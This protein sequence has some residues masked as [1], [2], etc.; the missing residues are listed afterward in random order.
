MSS[1]GIDGDALVT[2][3]IGVVG[4]LLTF[5]GVRVTA[6][7][8]EKASEPA[9]WQSLTVEMKKFFQEQLAERDKRIDALEQREASRDAYDRWLA[10]LSLPRP[11]FL[12]FDEWLTTRHD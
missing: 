3:I 10:T 7:S 8:N 1:G 5:F 11:P 6:R 4:A 12:H 2:L 9:S